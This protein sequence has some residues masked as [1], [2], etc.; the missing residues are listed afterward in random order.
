MAGLSRNV[1][2]A[3]IDVAQ[4]HFLPEA[5]KKNFITIALCQSIFHGLRAVT[6]WHV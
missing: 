4:P 2:H 6:A 5:Q 3:R 1:R